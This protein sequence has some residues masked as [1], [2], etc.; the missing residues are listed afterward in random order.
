VPIVVGRSFEPADAVS[1]GRVVIVNETLANRI[2]KGRSPIGQRVRPNLSAAIGFGGNA[3]HTVIGVAK[4]VKQGG[5]DQKT[6]TEFYFFVDQTSALP[7]PLGNAPAVMNV[8]LRTTLPPATLRQ[9]V[10]SAV[11]EADPSVPVVRL[12]EM[13][14]VFD[15]SIRR[16]RLLAQ[17]LGGFAGLALLL[18]AIGTY[19]VLSYMVAER[20]REIGI[21][22]ALGATAGAVVALVMRQSVRLAGIGAIIGLT[23]AFAALKFLSSLV[24]LKEV[25]LLNVAPFAI[26]LVLVLVATALAAYQP[27]RRATRV[28]P[29]ETLRAE[30]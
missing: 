26:A 10:E 2:W 20:R 7:P 30:A 22:M 23:I 11:R 5:V 17:L 8:A 19:G 21:R 29:A 13:D 1:P 27:A 28:D 3:W 6:G 25:S 15:E 4:D 12:R 14:A 9:S 18:A 24:R 16:Q